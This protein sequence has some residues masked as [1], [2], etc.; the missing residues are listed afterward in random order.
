MSRFFSKR[1]SALVPYVPGEQPK[2][3]KF[4]KLNTN[5]SPF[6][7][8]EKAFAYV[9]EAYNRCRLYPDPTLS[10]LRQ[11]FAELKGVDPVNVIFSNG[12]DDMLNFAFMAYCDDET[13]A[14]F[15]DI[16]YG[17]YPVFCDINRL[18]YIEIP[19][20]DDLSIDIRDYF[21]CGRTIFIANPNAPTGIAL[22]T[23]E[24]RQILDHN[25][26]DIVVI[27]E[28]YVDFGG[29]SSIPL[30]KEYDNL[31][32]IGTFSKSRSFAGG[33]LGYAIGNEELIGDIN[34]IRFSMNPYDIN[35]LTMA[36]AIGIIRDEAYTVECCSTIAKTR[37]WTEEKLKELG[38]EMTDSCAN[39]LFAKANGIPGETM[40]H[41]LR[42]RGIL[43]R[44]FPKER[45]RDYLRI[46]IGSEEEMT[47][48]IDAVRAIIAEE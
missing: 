14:A 21:E 16:T 34:T 29:E 37:K 22:S 48:L 31:L 36:G 32:V 42:E 5:E 25:P 38:F 28:A 3:R 6:P 20:E 8:S 46:T 40:Y 2:D 9:K 7:P 13:G 26:D 17:F 39:F 43:V 41:K 12:S 35:Q 18:D 11:A 24:I 19:L 10:E 23:D 44:H 30:T 47:A 4:I 33:R 45:I 15:P 1:L 27:D